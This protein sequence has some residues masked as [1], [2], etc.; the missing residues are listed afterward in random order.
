[1]RR[2]FGITAAV[3][4]IAACWAIGAIGPAGL[5]WAADPKEL[6]PPDMVRVF[7]T[8]SDGG[9]S[10]TVVWPPASYDSSEVRYQVLLGEAADNVD[11]SSLA[12]VAEF[13]A[14]TRYVRETKQP[15]W[16][17]PAND[18][19]HLYVMKNGK[20]V[21]LKDGIPYAV[22]LAVVS[23][24][25]RVVSP[26]VSAVPEPNWIN[27][28]QINNLFLA[29]LFGGIVFVS[30]GLAKKREM[31]LRRIPGLDAVDEAIGRATELGKPV[32][33]LTGAHDMSDPSTIAAAVILGRV[34]KR[35]AA[36]ETELMVPHREPITMAVCQEITKQAYL[37]AGK[38]DLYKED[39]NFFIT[40][41]QFS[42]TAAV[43]GIMLR[44]R[45]AANFFMGSYFA[46]SLLLTETGASTGAIQIAGTDSD[47]Q[48]PFFVT[49]CDYTLIGEELYAASAYLSRE[50]V[51]V[52]TLRG[53]DVGKALI[54][55]VLIIG[56]VLATIG[57]AAEAEWPRW[58]L[59]VFRDVK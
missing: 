32:L 21:G 28:N 57:V 59:D 18:D 29:V 52:G 27:W 54:L 26:I 37:E 10:L 12:V 35:A 56:T 40:S 45:P 44:K 53:Q 34:A 9:G 36:Y 42:Y 30:I 55:G 41:D 51:Q 8:P 13:P 39:S 7:D 14:N 33:Y 20:T 24:E 1:M 49:T 15:W 31:F 47:H 6:T 22:A 5:L 17:K 16:T 58:L 38:P 4:G 43:D 11:P 23:G 3:I 19:Q 50:P 2:R 46:E 25:Q 48:L